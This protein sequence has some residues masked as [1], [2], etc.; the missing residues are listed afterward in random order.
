MI[1]D[2]IKEALLSVDPVVFYGAV[3]DSMRETVWDYTVF[4]RSK[5]AFSQ[6]RTGAS[7]YFSVH[8]I[9]ENFIPVGLE[10]DV[11]EKML[12]IPGMRLAGNDPAFEYVQKPGTNIVVEMLT[13]E[14]V[15][16]VKR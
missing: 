8:V 5:I 13:I 15:L 12:A 2:E 11:I 6:N 14:F 7:Y 4:E 1:L 9:R 10:N 3:D 16:P